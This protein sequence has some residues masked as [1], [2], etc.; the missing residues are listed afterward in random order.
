LRRPSGGGVAVVNL[1]VVNLIDIVFNI[2]V[3]VGG[4]VVVDDN[5][6]ARD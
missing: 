4:V 5:A 1:I 3:A 2:V 6:G